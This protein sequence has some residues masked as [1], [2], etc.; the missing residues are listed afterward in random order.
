MAADDDGGR[1]LNAYLNFASPTGGP[2]FVGVSSFVEDGAG[3]YQLRVTDTDVPGHAYTDEL[4]DPA[5]DG[6][7]SRIEMPGDLDNYRVTLEGGVTYVIDAAGRGEHPLAD[8]F[9]AIVN[10]ENTRITSDDDGGA[11]KDA[12]LRFRPEASG[13]FLIQVSG[14]GG[15][16]GD[17]EVKIVRR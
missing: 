15:S 13:D 1:G 17:Y 11:G 10:D 3:R 12:R 2:Y 6:R 14:L 9:V 7:A 4:L 8:P 5:D 16:T